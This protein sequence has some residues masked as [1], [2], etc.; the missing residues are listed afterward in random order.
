[1]R[2]KITLNIKYVEFIQAYWVSLPEFLKKK[3]KK[4]S[5]SE[6]THFVYYLEL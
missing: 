2:A 4:Q 6:L 1:M 5:D 3:K